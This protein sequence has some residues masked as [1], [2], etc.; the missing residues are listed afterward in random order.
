[1]EGTSPVLDATVRD[2]S[3][4][5]LPQV[6]DPGLD[7]KGLEIAARIGD[8]TVDAPLDRAVAAAHTAQSVHSGHEVI[9]RVGIDPV[10]DGHQ[11]R[12][13]IGCCFDLDS[14]VGPVQ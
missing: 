3:P 7:Q 2:G 11:N 8:V 4:L 10:F 13:L 1:M 6:L 9:P 5:M 14:G 12:S